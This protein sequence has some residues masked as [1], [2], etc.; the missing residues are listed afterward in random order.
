MSDNFDPFNTA[1]NIEY[2]EFNREKLVCV[3]FQE[4]IL[5]N[6][7]RKGTVFKYKYLNERSN[8][9]SNIYVPNEII[10]FYILRGNQVDDKIGLYPSKIDHEKKVV[11]SRWL[12]LNFNEINRNSITFIAKS[13][14]NISVPP[15]ITIDCEYLSVI[16]PTK[17]SEVER[18]GIPIKS[19]ENRGG[20]SA[21]PSPNS[22]L[23]SK[24]MTEILNIIR[25]K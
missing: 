18:Q 12:P 21:S 17:T 22:G 3:E 8:G 23:S 20:L 24:D 5:E 19:R 9:L 4:N 15:E 2:S 10:E 1:N 11:V 6:K 16:S 7:K 13:I 14:S 25:Q